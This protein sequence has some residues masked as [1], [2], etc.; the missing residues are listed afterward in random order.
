[1]TLNLRPEVG[2]IDTSAITAMAAHDAH[3]VVQ[4]H[5]RSFPG[6]FL[7][8]MGVGFLCEFYASTVKDEGSVALVV[9]GGGGITGFVVGTTRPRGFYRR[10][11]GRAWGRFGASALRRVIESPITG[12]RLIRRLRWATGTEYAADD[13][14]LMSIAVLPE[15]S[16]DGTA[17]RLV[18]AFLEEARAHGA[19]RVRLT[20]DKNNNEH[21]N[22]FYRGIG[23]GILNTFVTAEGRRMNEYCLPLA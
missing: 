12:V 23:F 10:I 22:R 1:M 9:R 11:L 7:T 20:T 15:C 8:N 19:K 16:G 13:A 14:L 17:R 21:V 18:S 5:M 3:D 2:R 6:F 4:V